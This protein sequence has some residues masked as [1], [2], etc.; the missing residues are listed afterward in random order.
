MEPSA[1]Y[2]NQRGRPETFD[3]PAPRLEFADRLQGSDSTKVARHPDSSPQI[4]LLRH[5]L[6]SLG[7]TQA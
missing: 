1:I 2:Y 4:Q 3:Y 7:A 5:P 6:A